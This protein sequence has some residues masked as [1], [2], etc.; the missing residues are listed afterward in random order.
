MRALLHLLRSNA[1]SPN[2]KQSSHL[3]QNTKPVKNA[4]TAA[5]FVLHT[6]EAE[7]TKGRR[8][9]MGVCI[10]RSIFRKQLRMAGQETKISHIL[11][12]IAIM[13]SPPKKMRW[14]FILFIHKDQTFILKSNVPKM[15]A[16]IKMIRD[17]ADGLEYQVSF[18]DCCFLKTLQKEGVGFFWLA[19]NV[20]VVNA[21][22]IQAGKHRQQ[23]GRAQLQTQC[24]FKHAHEQMKH[25]QIK[26]RF[27]VTYIA[28]THYIQ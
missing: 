26:L 7:K 22:S 11:I 15:D 14:L 21:D 6:E 8:R 2:V 20:S 25:N 12:L 28:P 23:R 16:H 10:G 5:S 13:R 1:H 3:G 17:F 4:A 27:L 24:F 18:Q 9:R 19:E